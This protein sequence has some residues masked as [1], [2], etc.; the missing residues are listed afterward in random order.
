MLECYECKRKLGALESIA[1]YFRARL[2]SWNKKS[3]AEIAAE[4][5]KYNNLE[6]RHTED[7]RLMEELAM[8]YRELASCYKLMAES[9]ATIR[10]IYSEFNE[11]V[12]KMKE[13]E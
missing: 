11:K 2:D 9:V 4:R 7:R 3:Y 6:R 12:K 13:R 10:N 8:N 5:K 1:R